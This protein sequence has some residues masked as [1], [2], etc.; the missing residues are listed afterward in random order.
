M[1]YSVHGDLWKPGFHPHLTGARLLSLS[2]LEGWQ[3][4]PGA[5]PG[6]PS[7]SCSEEAIIL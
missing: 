3:R 2:L 6:L 7:L 5:E 4:R 1:F